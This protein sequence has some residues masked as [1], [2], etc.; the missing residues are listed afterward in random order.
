MKGKTA[1]QSHVGCRLGFKQET[2]AT[3]KRLNR[4]LVLSP[5]YMIIH[6][7]K[8][9]IIHLHDD[10]NGQTY[11]RAKCIPNKFYQHSTCINCSIIQ[12]HVSSSQQVL[13]HLTIFM[14][15]CMIMQTSRYWHFTAK[16]DKLKLHLQATY[17]G[18]EMLSTS[19][20]IQIEPE[21]ICCSACFPS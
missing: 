6:L 11:D 4:P 2:K 8:N 10:A 18:V 21:W 3:L 9:I 7:V 1:L 12:L 16:G 5:V 19:S 14:G 20:Y 15:K 17:L 13:K